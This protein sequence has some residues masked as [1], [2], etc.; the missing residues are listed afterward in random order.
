MCVCVFASV[1]HHVYVCIC[2]GVYETACFF[3]PPHACVTCTSTSC[4]CVYV[5]E[6]LLEVLP[7]VLMA[8]PPPLSLRSAAVIA[9]RKDLAAFM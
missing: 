8:T 2:V 5:R 6:A 4:L 9:D 1:A 3:F 7:F